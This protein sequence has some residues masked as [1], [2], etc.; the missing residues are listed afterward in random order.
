M[1]KLTLHVLT[2][3]KLSIKLATG[4]Y[5]QSITS[6]EE[7]EFKLGGY[8]TRASFRVLPL[9]IFYGILGMVW[10]AKHN[11]TIECKTKLLKFVTLLGKEVTIIGIG[12]NPKLQLV[13]ATT[14]LKSYRKKKMVYVVKLN[15]LENPKPSNEPPWWL[16][17]YVDVF[18]EETTQLPLPKD[19]DHAIDLIPRAQPIAKRPYNMSLLKTIEL[20]EQLTQLLD[21]GFIKPS[22]SPWSVL[23]LFNHKKDGTLCLCIDYHG[24]NQS[25]IKNKYPIPRIDELLDRLH[26]SCIFTKIDLKSN[27]NQRERY[28]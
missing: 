17:E 9:G 7:L 22:V 23:V 14:L 8:Q 26:G 24:L 16:V 3:S 28:L 2:K 6:I 12:G 18:P 25:T 11:A 1:C 15:P 20:K 4:Q 10:L 21:H 19:V 5:A 13:I 27:Q